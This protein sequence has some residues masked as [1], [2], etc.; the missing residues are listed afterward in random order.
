MPSL[1][2]NRELATD[3]V[4][5]GKFRGKLEAEMLSDREY[6]QWLS[7]EPGVPALI[8]AAVADAVA[9]RTR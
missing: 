2:Q 7:R 4:T 1:V 3:I 5:F 6:C 9:T 8:A